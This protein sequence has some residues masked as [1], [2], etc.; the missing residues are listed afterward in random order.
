MMLKISLVA[1]VFVFLQAAS[2]QEFALLVRNCRDK[3]LSRLNECLV[4]AIKR[5]QPQLGDG[6]PSL[7]IPPMEPLLLDDI[8]FRQAEGPVNIEARYRKVMVTGASMFDLK[9]FDWFAE[10]KK[11]FLGMTFPMM[12]MTGQYNL[13][14]NVFQLP[15]EGNGD[16]VVMLDGIVAQSVGEISVAADGSTRL[17]NMK[18]NF[19]IMKMKSKLMNLFNGNQVLSETLHHFLNSNS[20]VVLDEVRPEISRQL[21][22]FV[23]NLL[24]ALISSL[25]NEVLST[26]ENSNTQDKHRQRTLQVRAGNTV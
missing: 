2:A 12:I 15:V 23:T 5:I 7:N 26:I 4:S 10:E 18:L 21:S 6:I 19:D 24:Q 9:Y 22:G 3:H 1:V 16:F 11:M 8:L 13:T 17:S 20:Q 25:P 14:G